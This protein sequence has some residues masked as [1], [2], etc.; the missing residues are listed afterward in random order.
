MF[1]AKKEHYLVNGQRNWSLLRK[2]VFAVQQ[3]CKQHLGGRLPAKQDISQIL[4]SALSE[5]TSSSLDYYRAKQ[6]QSGKRKRE[7]PFKPHLEKYGIQFP[8]KSD[9]GSSSPCEKSRDKSHTLSPIMATAPE[10]ELQENEQLAMVIRESLRNTPQVTT[11]L[12]SAQSVFPICHQTPAPILEN[13]PAPLMAPF[14]MPMSMSMYPNLPYMQPYFHHVETPSL[15]VPHFSVNTALPLLH[16]ESIE[17][18]TK[19]NVNSNEETS[20]TSKFFD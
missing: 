6:S 9:K 14:A 15:C 5:D 17:T 4:E 8:D 16:S 19:D 12:N 1:E 10:S 11:S 7:N 3:Y 2:H 13:Y 18:S 20:E